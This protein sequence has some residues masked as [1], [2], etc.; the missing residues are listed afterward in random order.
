L[1]I[2]KV[3]F[4]VFFTHLALGGPSSFLHA[5]TGPGKPVTGGRR[6]LVVYNNDVPFD[7]LIV[8]GTAGLLSLLTSTGSYAGTGFNFTVEQIQVPEA[9]NAGQTWASGSSYV[10]ANAALPLTA[11]NYCIIFDLRFN[12][13][14]YN[15]GSGLAGPRGSNYVRGDTIVQADVNAY[16]SYLASGGGL[17]ILGDNYWDDSVNRADGF[18][19]RMETMVQMINQVASTGLVN[20]TAFKLGAPS[21]ASVPSGSNPYSLE[22]D[23]NALN[24]VTT[25]YPGPIVG[26]GSGKIFSHITGQPS[27]GVGV[28][29]DGP[30]GDLK[31]AYSAGRMVYW[32]DVSAVND[33]A[34]GGS[35]NMRPMFENA[36]DYLFNDTCCTAPGGTCGLPGQVPDPGDHP[37]VACFTG[38][39]NGWS[40]LATYS[41]SWDASGNGGGSLCYNSAGWWSQSDLFV[42]NLT[43]GDLQL[44]DQICLTVRN[45]TG[46]N[47]TFEV[48][49]Q[50]FDGNITANFTVNA[51]ATSTQCLAFTG[52]Y[53]SAAQLRIRNNTASGQS[54]MVCLDDVKLRH[55]CGA[56]PIVVDSACCS[57]SSPTVTPTSSPTRT[58]TPTATPTLTPTS[59]RTATP[60]ASPSATATPTASFTV[61]PTFTPTRTA[62][63]TPSSSA[64]PTPTFSGTPTR[65]FTSTATFSS[66][67]T[68][69]FTPTSS[70]TATPTDSPTSSPGPSPTDTSTRTATPSVS[71][72]VTPTPSLTATTPYSPT[73]TP[74]T[75][76]SFTSSQTSTHTPS[77]TFTPSATPSATW[78]L[79]YSPS[80]SPSTTS[81]ATPTPSVTGTPTATPT[82]TSTATLTATRTPS[83][84]VT[85]TWTFSVSPTITQT[86]VPLPVR[87]SVTLYNSAGERVRLLFEGGAQ[88][89]PSGV[90]L[91]AATLFSGGSGV[92]LSL[93][94]MLSNGGSTLL[95]AGE[96]DGGQFVA[97]GAY[98]FKV[99]FSDSFGSVTAYVLHVQVL[100]G[101]GKQELAIY[102]SAG[103]RVWWTTA[104]S[105][106]AGGG[107]RLDRDVV[108]P[109]GGVPSPL[110]GLKIFL[111]G[112]L[113]AVWDGR[114][115]W[116]VPVASG[117][118]LVQFVSI[119]PNGSRTVE[120]KEITVLNADGGPDLD[121]VLGPN[122]WQGRGPLVLSYAPF[123]GAV[124]RCELYNLAGER[125]LGG[126]DLSA[127][128]RITLQTD[129]LAGG[130]YWL[131][132]RQ[133]RG[134]SLL[135][136]RVKKLAVIK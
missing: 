50:N 89:V 49:N 44:Y 120:S 23:F 92:T 78:T 103:E 115:R 131:E 101:M 21:V 42:R 53:G 123:P 19:S 100:N 4:F 119:Q 63:P 130:I 2:L 30:A 3:A 106:G 37:V 132:F 109:D 57:P 136:R 107:L 124:A 13:K 55:S 66:T 85:V 74:S 20:D 133:T 29:W 126:A 41:P 18:I 93:N 27:Q 75:T 72:T 60:S 34:G 71:P 125:V 58:R 128:G 86:P 56:K 129:A 79:T 8:N 32:G 7:A 70:R 17:F 9:H 51:G 114:D 90:A 110:S 12:N 11:S 113:V 96:N 73:A 91:S 16:A 59:S 77:R 14:N 121:P 47:M 10:A 15:G 81:T 52:A 36:I 48:W 64:S 38:G 31:P 97:S 26:T 88:A 80:A 69:S 111:G 94:T 54:G 98:Y 6:V 5:N 104:V 1:G 39:A 112:M 24:T 25:L 46:V 83:P 84:S 61:T 99:E 87:V 62:S 135:G 67:F 108:V 105:A 117:S 68:P 82:R 76:P 45:T 40:G 122:P 43:A 102:N 65:T 95:W 118:Y 35:I 28:V 134:A 22:S 33:W 116:G 127:S